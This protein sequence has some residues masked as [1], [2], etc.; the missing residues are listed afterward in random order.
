MKDFSTV[1][2]KRIKRERYAEEVL[3]KYI[4]LINFY[5]VT[6]RSYTYYKIYT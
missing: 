3:Q 4:Y 6:S 1:K 5:T 2:D